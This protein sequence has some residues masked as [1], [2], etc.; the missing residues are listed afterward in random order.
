MELPRGIELM[1]FVTSPKADVWMVLAVFELNSAAVAS[2]FS[3]FQISFFP[4]PSLLNSR[5]PLSCSSLFFSS[6]IKGQH[7]TLCKCQLFFGHTF[8]QTCACTLT[9]LSP[10]RVS[11][12]GRPQVD[13][14]RAQPQVRHRPQQC[15]CD[16]VHSLKLFYLAVTFVS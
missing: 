9:S 12:T 15:E 6:L 3:F 14:R 4:S 10:L 13:P 5:V 7:T 11:P 2:S 1:P 16:R 8:T